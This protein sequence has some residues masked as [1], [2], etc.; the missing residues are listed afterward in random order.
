MVET[1]RVIHRRYLLQRLVKQ[2]QVCAIYQ[3][4][5][6]IL[7]RMVVIKIVPAAHMTVY[8]AAIR[9]TSQFSHP[10]IVGIYDLIV[11]P[12][13][14]Y[15]VQE[16]I[17]GDDFPAMLQNQFTP[18]QV[19]EFG[20]QMCYALMYAGSATR[21]VCHG[22]LTPAAVLRDRRGQIRLNNFA[23]PSDLYYFTA[24]SSIGNDGIIVADR[25]LPWGQ[26]TEARRVDDVRA[27]GILLYQLLSGRAPGAMSVD[28]PADG[29]LR[30]LRNVPA[31]L[32]EII[33]RSIVRQHP[34]RISNAEQLHAELKAVADALEPPLSSP[35]SGSYLNDEPARPRQMSPTPM[36]PRKTGNLA[37][38]LP[39][40][41]FGQGDP[42]VPAAYAVD[43]PP[44]AFEASPA[45][46]TV[47]DMSMSVKLAG[48]RQ[49]AYP[50]AGYE[51]AE[52]TAR[53]PNLLLLLLL[54]LLIFAAFFGI[55]YFIATVLVHR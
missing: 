43:L 4:Y 34:Q 54:G 18:Y 39:N 27:V 3:G 49:A 52:R 14:L 35:I 48:A 16:H 51:L 13:A 44:N 55:G 41:E 24:W 2:G 50:Q 32:C 45:A 23:L 26:L 25:E 38:A 36:P 5:D 22:D 7:Q 53:R 46:P 20:M 1:D 30:F 21:K 11:E 19:T 40:R 28:P 31:E 9:Q 33:A 10:N 29:R 6:Q 15:I 42:L 8:R 17:D 47:A 12:E 37:T